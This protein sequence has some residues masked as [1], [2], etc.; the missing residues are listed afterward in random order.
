MVL[1]FQ[2]LWLEHYWRHLQGLLVL[3]LLPWDSSL[4]TML[5]N[6]YNPKLYRSYNGSRHIRANNP[7]INSFNF[8]WRC[9]LNAYQQSQLKMGIFS[10]DTVSVGD[11]FAGSLFGTVACFFIYFIS[12]SESD[13]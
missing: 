4:P 3:L 6:G 12:I 10:P 7:S 8:V 2:L 13:I 9:Y 1:V 5:Q 11:L